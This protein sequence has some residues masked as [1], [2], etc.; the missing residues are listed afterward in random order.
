MQR[1]ILRRWGL[2]LAVTG[3]FFS[4]AACAHVE[5]T[6]VEATE[7]NPV[8]SVE[9][10]SERAL[11]YLNEDGTKDY[12]YKVKYR[13]LRTESLGAWGHVEAVWSPWLQE[14]PKIWVKVHQ[15]DGSETTLDPKVFTRT[16]VDGLDGE[17]RM[18]ILAPL[19]QL[20]PGSVVEERIEYKS[21]K[22]QLD[23][24]VSE[25]FYFGMQVPVAN[26]ELVIN[27]PENMSL[28]IL[29]RGVS[30]KPTIRQVDGRRI[31]S[32]QLKNLPARMEVKPY[33]PVDQPRFPY[34]AFS[35]APSW[36][37][38]AVPLAA[39]FERSLRAAELDKIALN[40]SKDWPIEKLVSVLLS[41][42]LSAVQVTGRRFGAGPVTPMHPEETLIRETGDG[43]DIAL[44]LVGALRAT[45]HN[46]YVA[47]LRS[48]PEEDLRPELPGLAGLDRAVV[49]VEQDK[50]W[51]WV[52]PVD[53]F[54]P[55][56]QLSTS[57][58]G[59]WALVVNEATKELIRAPSGRS[60][61][62]QYMGYR[63]I[64]LPAYGRAAVV[65]ETQTTG[66]IA[67]HQRA[68]LGASE[69]SDRA[70]EKYAVSQLGA[71]SLT[72][73]EN[74]LE[75]LSAPV[76]FK[77]HANNSQLGVVDLHEAS[78]D[79]RLAPLFSW[80]PL[81]LRQTL[82]KPNQT[83]ELSQ[84]KQNF[85]R[86]NF[87][88]F[89]V[90]YQAELRYEINPPPGFI[91]SEYP[92]D[93]NLTL[94]PASYSAKY[95]V[96]DGKLL[97]DFKFSTGPKE[98]SAAEFSELVEGL[99][100][101]ALA[102]TLRV[103]YQHHFRKILSEGKIQEALQGFADLSSQDPTSAE[104]LARLAWAL[105]DV[106]FGDAARQVAQQAVALQPQSV[107][108]L[109]TLGRVLSHDLVGRYHG[110]GFDRAGAMAA[111]GLVKRLAPNHIRA[112]AEL[113]LL[114][115]TD[116][117]GL[118]SVEED[119][120][121]AV[122]MEY[123]DL[124]KKIGLQLF[125]E[126]YLEALLYS[127][128]YD[129]VFKT[130]QTISPSVRRDGI[131]VA[132][133]VAVEQSIDS[134]SEF[135]VDI[136]V[137]SRHKPTVLA[138]AAV[139]LATLGHYTLASQMLTQIPKEQQGKDFSQQ[140]ARLA[141][142]R[143]VID[144]LHPEDEPIGVVQRIISR[145]LV[146]N[147]KDEYS[148]IPFSVRLTH[149]QKEEQEKHILHKFSAKLREAFYGQVP[150]HL[151]RDDILSYTHFEVESSKLGVARVL[152]R[153]EMGSAMAWFLRREP[154]AEKP[155]GRYRVL[156]TSLM[157]ATLGE[158]AV[159]SFERGNDAEAKQWLEWARDG[160]KSTNIERLDFRRPPFQALFT[161]QSQGPLW[162][163]WSLCALGQ[164]AK[165]QECLKNLSDATPK[166]TSVLK[167]TLINAQVWGWMA[168]RQWGRALP[169]LEE[170][171]LRHPTNPDLYSL[172]MSG[173]FALE[174]W[175]KAEQAIRRQLKVVPK[176]Q[177]PLEHLANLKTAKGQ[178]AEAKSILE[179]LISKEPDG[180]SILYNNLAWVSLF[181]GS[182][183]E[184][185]LALALKANTMSSGQSPAELHTLAALH[186]E[187]GDAQQ[188]LALV[189]RRLDLL[190]VSEPESMDYYLFGRVME[191][192][193]LT[194]LAEEAY[195]KVEKDEGN[196]ADS[197]YALAQRRLR[198]IAQKRSSI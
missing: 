182:V 89:S 165:A 129:D 178:F 42:I 123:A 44:L 47:L 198:Q 135:I 138:T 95:T 9:V 173:Y 56:G 77:V 142:T 102:P 20:E 191:Q 86:N 92:K 145:L 155:A 115:G 106:G 156:A 133:K 5:R 186:A 117:R 171:Q 118:K 58:E 34:V 93:R 55:I 113:A 76:T 197:T 80:L 24:L 10:L 143:R 17:S 38:V 61:S 120:M 60:E 168:S 35:N 167:D 107:G 148:S 6:A 69:N 146:G 32:Y 54:I 177:Q 99:R 161:R 139:S 136:E 36:S 109:F 112:R 127:K 64:D 31:S 164:G 91:L 105:I 172:T 29:H 8:A 160:K 70:F 121:V 51:L 137:E 180:N 87:F 189:R 125:D 53:E 90:P 21:V 82:V 22:P 48:A 18:R 185:D 71:A 154:T 12:E 141:G 192:L 23:K 4:L 81:E 124:R 46:A 67:A 27:A 157:P 63:R 19:S 151:L 33:I 25:R 78:V 183:E 79:I 1:R 41:R 11:Y 88:N 128:Q 75:D 188:T 149:E 26:S 16:P 7:K 101:L 103:R 49:V 111:L 59:R 66:S 97:G 96:R 196:R 72:S 62:N 132:A 119:R 116:D 174:Q 73:Y 187:Q 30:V 14:Q 13:V 190:R 84:I 147:T 130:A 15:P 37:A 195:M 140:V 104:Q 108:A 193:G 68:Q 57:L 85:A 65:E 100:K 159:I 74:K 158:L 162:A 181:Q 122:A 144:A 83:K 94:G 40:L 179:K 3:A 126:A 184:S 110:P 194:Q 39:I 52:D 131:L 134:A 150:A 114:L 50:E 28:E 98:Y 175:S 169:L 43:D 152:M 163:A 166:R 45:G 176:S 153:D 2:V 170:L